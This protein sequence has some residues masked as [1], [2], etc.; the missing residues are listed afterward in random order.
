MI[1][2]SIP[3][4]HTWCLGSR[5]CVGSELPLITTMHDVVA[6]HAGPLVQFAISPMSEEE[7][8][9]HTHTFRHILNVLLIDFWTQCS[10][11][12]LGKH[13][14]FPCF[15]TGSHYVSQARPELLFLP[16]PPPECNQGPAPRPP[17]LALRFNLLL[18]FYVFKHLTFQ[19]TCNCG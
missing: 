11:I 15:H 4:E 6:S 7:T 14:S 9:A 19:S 8:E 1:Q 18:P 12:S 16:S 17:C 3:A 5:L 10:P 13:H 2:L